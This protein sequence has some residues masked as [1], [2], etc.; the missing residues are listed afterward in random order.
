MRYYVLSIEHNAEK[1][2]ENR[3]A[4]KAYDK[5]DD[6]IR[7]FYS[8]MASDMGNASLDWALVMVINSEMGVEKSEKWVREAEP[9]VEVVEESVEE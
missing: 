2:A 5:R 8:T 9:I 3:T 4:P 1:N 7:Q 6:A